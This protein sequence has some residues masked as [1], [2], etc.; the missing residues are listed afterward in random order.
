ML[1]I[2]ENNI[3]ALFSICDK[4]EQKSI[5][6]QLSIHFQMAIQI[7]FGSLRRFFKNMRENKLC[8]TVRVIY[9]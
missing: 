3:L 9:S 2:I 8:M 5:Y 1:A 4:L 7:L 6:S